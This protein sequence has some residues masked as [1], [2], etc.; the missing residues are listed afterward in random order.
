[1]KPAVDD[2][3]RLKNPVAEVELAPESC[4]CLSLQCMLIRSL[5]SMGSSPPPSKASSLPSTNFICTEKLVSSQPHNERADLVVHSS[6]GMHVGLPLPLI[7]LQGCIYAVQLLCNN[8]SQHGAVLQ[9]HTQQSYWVPTALNT[10][11]CMLPLTALQQCFSAVC[12]PRLSIPRR[13]TALQQK[14]SGMFPTAACRTSLP[15][16]LSR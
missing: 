9:Q 6:Q 11:A 1:M 2:E 3:V 5:C 14:A 12:T 16:A 15:H 10:E 7:A 4:K 8:V 13:S